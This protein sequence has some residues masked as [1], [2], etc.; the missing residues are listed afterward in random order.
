MT[1]RGG[2]RAVAAAVCLGLGVMKAQNWSE[3]GAVYRMV[4][5]AEVA[6]GT[7]LAAGWRPR[8]ADTATVLMGFGFSVAT[9]LSGVAGGC[10]CLGSNV[11]AFGVRLALAVGLMLLGGAGLVSHSPARSSI[12]SEARASEAMG[13]L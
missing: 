1:Y 9:L 12:A 13:R 11:R 8:L 5:V 2:L 4:A 6:I 7:A 3:L 10:Q